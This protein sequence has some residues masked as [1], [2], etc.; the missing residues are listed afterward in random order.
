MAR[1]HLI[2]AASP[3]HCYLELGLQRLFD[4]VFLH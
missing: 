4:T 2:L 1:E 3:A